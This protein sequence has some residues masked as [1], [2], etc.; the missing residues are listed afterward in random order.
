MIFIVFYDLDVRKKWW[1][2]CVF[3]VGLHIALFASS[4]VWHQFLTRIFIDFLYIF[5]G[6]WLVLRIKMGMKMNS[7]FHCNFLKKF[8]VLLAPFGL[9]FASLGV[10]WAAKWRPRS[11]PDSCQNGVQPPK[12]PRTSPGPYF[13]GIR[14]WFLEAFGASGTCLGTLLGDLFGKFFVKPS[15]DVSYVRFKI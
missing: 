12:E 6:F 2:I 9:T 7:D 13:G 4:S 15:C 10:I 14:G 3:S 8:D 5:T 1:I 11:V